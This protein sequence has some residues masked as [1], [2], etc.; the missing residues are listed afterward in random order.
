MTDNLRPSQRR[1]NLRVAKGLDLL[2]PEEQADYLG[3]TAIADDLTALGVVVATKQAT[4]VSGTNI[5]T[6]N[7]SSL[8]GPGD[9]IVGGSSDPLIGWFA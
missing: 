3:I 2:T 8:L 9:L 6:V 5:K 1:G 4:L 7:G